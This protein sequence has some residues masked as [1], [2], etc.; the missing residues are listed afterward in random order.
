MKKKIFALLIAVFFTGTMASGCGTEEKA[1]SASH[2]E[3]KLT[4]GYVDSGAS[5]PNDITGIAIDQGYFEEELSKAGYKFEA[6]P[7]TG[8]GPAI[9]EAMVNGSIDIAVTGDVPAI[10]GKSN[11]VEDT[12]IGAELQFNDAA[13]VVLASS[14]IHSVSDL[15]GKTVA[16]LQG[17]YMHK[18]LINMLEAEGLSIEDVQFT[19]M[20]SADAAVAV[21]AGAV[22]AAVVAN[23]QEAAIANSEN[24]RIVENCEKHPEWKGGHA[25]IARDEYLTEGKE[26]AVAFLKAVRRAQ[27]YALENYDSAIETLAKS[28][29]TAEVYRFFF[30]DEVNLNLSGGDEVLPVY[31]GIVEF[32]IN[33]EL[34]KN[35]PDLTTWFDKSIWEAAK[36]D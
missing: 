8:A 5:F 27:K 30:P 4:F 35:E 19:S 23:T 3:K 36:L 10:I 31:E 17:S 32:L 15:K 33:N 26:A 18:T 24:V 21:E 28:G 6:V 13:L 34:I 25:F 22:D 14:D 2:V 1:A 16:T 9:N 12:L 7:F 11:G 20:P 29:A